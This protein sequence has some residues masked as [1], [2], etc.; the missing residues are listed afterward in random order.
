M[1]AGLAVKKNYKVQYCA[2]LVSRS[3]FS[4]VAKALAQNACIPFFFFSDTL[5]LHYKYSNV[6]TIPPSLDPSECGAG[7][8]PPSQRA[9]FGVSAVKLMDGE[10]NPI[11]VTERQ[12]DPR[13][14]PSV[15]TRGR[16]AFHGSSNV[17]LSNRIG[18]PNL[19][20]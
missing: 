2:R 19:L 1:D 3:V 7:S 16:Q 13:S 8:D 18:G 5:G 11:S 15:R 17:H 9:A 20:N 14:F 6:M 10:L 4:H 12:T